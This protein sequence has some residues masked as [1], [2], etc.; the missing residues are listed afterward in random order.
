MKRFYYIIENT[1]KSLSRNGG[2][3][4]KAKVYRIGRNGLEYL[5]ETRQ[6]NTASYSGADNEVN[7]WLVTN[8]IIPKSWSKGY[9]FLDSSPYRGSYYSPFYRNN[10]KYSIDEIY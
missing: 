6:W 1:T 5:G 10:D 8:K 9:N 3:K 7:E 2:R 4:Q